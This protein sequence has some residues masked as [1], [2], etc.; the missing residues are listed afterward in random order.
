MSFPQL[1]V[2]VVSC[3]ICL[4][5]QRFKGGKIWIPL[6]ILPIIVLTSVL[7]SATLYF[8]HPLLLL[9]SNDPALSGFGFLEKCSWLVQV[10][11]GGPVRR[12]PGARREKSPKAR[13]REQVTLWAQSC[14]GPFEGVP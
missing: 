10:I 9:L 8:T 14:W 12:G 1:R 11:P 2:P 4:R 5:S 6:P 7:S 3:T 13:I